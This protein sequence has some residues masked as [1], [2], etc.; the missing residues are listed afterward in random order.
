MKVVNDDK[1]CAQTIGPDGPVKAPCY[2]YTYSYD[3]YL[4]KG[5]KYFQ[6]TWQL[7]EVEQGKPIDIFYSYMGSTHNETWY[8]LDSTENYVILVDCSYM[9]GWTN[10]GSI[11]WVR[12]HYQLTDSEMSSIARVYKA[13]MNWNFPQDFCNDVH[14]D[15]QCTEPKNGEGRRH[16]FHE[17]SNEQDLISSFFLN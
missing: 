7:P 9:S 6:Q 17:T 1:W 4:N 8:L 5:T 11:L 14:G 13:K 2:S 12:P 10:V 15:N 16:I 3:L